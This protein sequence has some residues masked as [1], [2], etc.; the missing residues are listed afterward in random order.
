FVCPHDNCQRAFAFNYL[1]SRHLLT[2]CPDTPQE[3][4]RGAGDVKKGSPKG[5]KKEREEKE[6]EK[7]DEELY[8]CQECEMAFS[9]RATFTKHMATHLKQEEGEGGGDKREGA[10]RGEE[11]KG[12]GRGEGGKGAGSGEEGKGVG[13]REGE[14]GEGVG[15]E[16][17]EGEE[18]RIEE[19]EEGGGCGEREREAMDGREEEEGRGG[20]KKHLESHLRQQKRYLSTKGG[21]LKQQ[22][23]QQ[24]FNLKQREMLLKEE[25]FHLRH[26]EEHLKQR[27][28]YLMQQGDRIREQ[29]EQQELHVRRTRMRWDRLVSCSVKPRGLR[30]KVVVSGAVRG[31]TV[32]DGGERGRAVAVSGGEGG[33]VVEDGGRGVC[34]VKDEI[35]AVG[36]P[37]DVEHFLHIPIVRKEGAVLLLLPHKL[38]IVAQGLFHIH[39]LLLVLVPIVL[40][41]SSCFDF[42]LLCFPPPFAI[43]HSKLHALC[44]APT[45][46]EEQEK[47]ELV[48]RDDLVHLVTPL[49]EKNDTRTEHLAQPSHRIST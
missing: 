10:G 7:E 47:L 31:R 45:D 6:R 46:L 12:E 42:T 38:L 27:K 2:H 32:E 28:E 30:R 26:L 9:H 40:V 29:K 14:K 16:G 17:D 34:V 39:L 19:E 35:E 24:E 43:S 4:E 48:A 13:R 41:G 20:R 8:T 3:G 11:G 49:P 23:E 44:E 25:E 21:Y 18:V 15:G 22:N 37:I 5:K 36:W 33:K 1:L